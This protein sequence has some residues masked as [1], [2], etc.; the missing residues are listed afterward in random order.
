M[1]AVRA[2]ELAGRGSCSV[3]DECM[4]DADLIEDWKGDLYSDPI[5]S[6]EA[7]VEWAIDAESRYREQA[8]NTREGNDDDPQLIAYREW[9]ERLET[10]RAKQ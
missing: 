4:S 6:P 10:W 2:N 1:I 8:L 7:A 3:V 9:N 5:T